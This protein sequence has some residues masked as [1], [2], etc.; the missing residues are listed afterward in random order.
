V[1][2]QGRAKVFVDLGDRVRAQAEA[3]DFARALGRGGWLIDGGSFRNY[4][5]DMIEPWGGPPADPQLVQ[6]ADAVS[7]LWRLWRRGELKARDRRFVG[8]QEAPVFASWVPGSDGVVL[9]VL[10]ADELHRRWRRLWEERGLRVTVAQADGQLVL[11][12]VADGVELSSAK[13]GL[14]FVLRIADGSGVPASSDTVRRGFVIAGIGLACALMMA[15]SYGLYRITMRE[16]LLARQQSDFVAAVSHEFRTPLTSMRHLLDLLVSRGVTDE[17]RKAEYYGLLAGETDRLQRM[18]ETLL[19]FGRIDAAAHVWTREPL[20]IGA[21]VGSVADMFAREHRSRSLVKDVDAGLPAVRGDGEAL[22]RA[23]WNLLE[24]AAKYS[25]DGSPIRVF[26]HRE[27]AAVVIGV[28]DHGMGIPLSERHRVFQKFVRGQEAKRAGI[29]GVGVGLAL[30]KRI[31]EAHGGRVRL[32]SEVGAGST[33]TLV[34]PA[35]SS[36]LEIPN[37]HATEAAG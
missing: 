28:E 14:P 5:H 4:Q 26:A 2:R 18:V 6:R 19:S 12:T 11:G 20:D 8:D 32:A 31:V 15:A 24:N 37:S 27:D 17:N 22:E 35:V 1:A 3:V 7:E 13:T 34:L 10:T 29:R 33:F 21:V 30:V 9:A 25:T 23:L 16:L 36:E